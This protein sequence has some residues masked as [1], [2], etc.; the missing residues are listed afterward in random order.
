MKSSRPLK[1]RQDLAAAAGLLLLPHFIHLVMFLW[2]V[3]FELLLVG[4]ARQGKARQEVAA[5]LLLPTTIGWEKE[6][7]AASPP[8]RY[9]FS[10]SPLHF[11]QFP[12]FVRSI[13]LRVIFSRWTRAILE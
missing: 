13:R 5:G 12:L 3:L 10:P 6:G 2:L 9:F 8:P 4:K 11:N 7:T 1:A